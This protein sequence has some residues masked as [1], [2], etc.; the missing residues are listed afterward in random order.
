MV[1]LVGSGQKLELKKS[2]L[3]MCSSVKRNSVFEA[4]KEEEKRH[5]VITLST[6]CDARHTANFRVD[7][8]KQFLKVS[9]TRHADVW[10]WLM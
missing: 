4:K 3:R 2:F 6:V 7:V 1:L 10:S 9:N 5:D 8:K